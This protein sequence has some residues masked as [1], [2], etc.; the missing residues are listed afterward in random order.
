MKRFILSIISLV[1]VM[2]LGTVPSYLPTVHAASKPASGKT[3]HKSPAPE[4]VNVKISGTVTVWSDAIGFSSPKTDPLHTSAKCVPDPTKGIWNL[5]VTKLSMAWNASTT[6]TLQDGKVASGIFRP[7][8][9]AA[10]LTIPLQ[11]APLVNT[12]QFKVSTDGS[13][14]TPT[15]QIIRGSRVDRKGNVTL[16]GSQLHIGL[17]NNQVEVRIQGIISPWPLSTTPPVRAAARTKKPALS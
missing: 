16:V 10:S 14:K 8:T 5:T 4:V 9:N 13:V 6:L 2:T 1:A 12:I 7:S 11:H 15:G 3:A 17:L